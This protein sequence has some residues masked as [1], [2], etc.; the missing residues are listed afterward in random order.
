MNIKNFEVHL[1]HGLSFSRQEGLFEFT[2]ESSQNRVGVSSQ[3]EL[4][5]QLDPP[6]VYKYIL[7]GMD[8]GFLKVELK[9]MSLFNNLLICNSGLLA[10]PMKPNK[11]VLVALPNS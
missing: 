8:C 2:F 4:T 6:L 1:G 9:L 5:R 7:L 3:V 10:G 11:T